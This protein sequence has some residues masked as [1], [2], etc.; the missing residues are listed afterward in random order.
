MADQISMV[1]HYVGHL[2]AHP[3]VLPAAP[4]ASRPILV[5]PS[6][7]DIPA[8]AAAV[9]DASAAASAT[10]LTPAAPKPS[11][12]ASPA[13]MGSSTVAHCAGPLVRG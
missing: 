8:S 13:L 6:I 3:A 4:E 2:S 11:A 9:A 7:T 12:V 1:A 5:A 10:L